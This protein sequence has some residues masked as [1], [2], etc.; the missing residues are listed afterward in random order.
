MVLTFL[1]PL[2]PSA[3][4]SFD[5]RAAHPMSLLRQVAAAVDFAHTAGVINGDVQPDVVMLNVNADAILTELG[6]ASL[7]ERAGGAGR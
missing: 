4:R 5:Q 6:V 1:A 2:E 3:E 7:H